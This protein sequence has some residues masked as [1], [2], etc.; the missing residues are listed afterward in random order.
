MNKIFPPPHKIILENL[1]VFSVFL[2]YV[3]ACILLRSRPIL[4]I[5]VLCVW[6]FAPLFFPHK[7]GG[8]GGVKAPLPPPLDPRLDS[9]ICIS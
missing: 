4:I 3:L 2:G 5:F 8:G 1:S 6:F 9:C 7:M